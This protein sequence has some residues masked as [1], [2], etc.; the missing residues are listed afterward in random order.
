MLV[1]H[2]LGQGYSGAS[3]VTGI[4]IFNKYCWVVSKRNIKES[5]YGK[6]IKKTAEKNVSS[7]FSYTIFKN[8]K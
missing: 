6:V 7:E 5:H 3:K 8:C 1:L 4:K 2:S